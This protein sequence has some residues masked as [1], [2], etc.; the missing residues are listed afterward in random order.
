MSLSVCLLTRNEE[1]HIARALR[2]VAG[3][4]DEVVVADTASRDRT[5]QIAADLGARVLQFPWEDDFASGR[6]FALEHATGDWVLWL[7]AS[8]ELLP[9]SHQAVR[10]C[11]ARDGVF[12]YFVLVQQPLGDDRPDAFA[13][14]QDLRLFR[15]RPDLAFVGRL[16]PAPTPAAVEAVRR[17]GQAVA[18]CAVTLRS[19][20]PASE[21]SEAKLRWTVRLLELELRDRPGQLH[22]L[23]EYGRTLLLLNDP[24]GHA[25]LAEAAEQVLAA[26]DAPAAP[27]LKVQLLLEY[28]LDTPPDAPRGRLTRDEAEGLALRWFPASP[29][30]LYKCAEG[31]FRR[32]DYRRAKGLLERLVHLGR[33]GSYDRSRAFDPGLVGDDALINLA[34]CY[35]QLGELYWAERCYRKLLG[36]RHYQAQ[37]AR[38]LAAVQAPQHPSGSFSFTVSPGPAP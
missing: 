29:P 35:Q 12:G 11:M 34:A 19:A 4:A 37:A 21:R 33:T 17:D 28:L 15:R 25:V 7:N 23:I 16:H 30:L 3:L 2:S 31:A 13:E 8:E 36:S 22:Y 26:R 6:N 18:A 14:A 5:A 24:R 9:S 10:E 32:G 1:R 38:G 20:E 27:A